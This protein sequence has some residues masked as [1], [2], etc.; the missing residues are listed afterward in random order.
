MTTFEMPK[1]RMGDF[2]YY[3]P[4]EDAEPAVGIVIGIS[5][6]SL[7]IWVI[8]PTYGGTE[9][10][11]VHHKDDPGLKEYEEWKNFGTWEHR[12]EDPRIAIL[13]EKVALLEK[14]LSAKAK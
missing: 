4:H 10:F 8:V 12:P 3:Y 7:S 2:V 6:R 9:K 11:S 13:S 14:K 5:Q 1:P